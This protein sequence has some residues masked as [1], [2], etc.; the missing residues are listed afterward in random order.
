MLNHG[1]LVSCGSQQLKSSESLPANLNTRR[2]PGHFSILL[3]LKPTNRNFF[4][5][6]GTVAHDPCSVWCNLAAPLCSLQPFGPTSSAKFAACSL[7]VGQY[8]CVLIICLELILVFIGA[9]CNLQVDRL[10][11]YWRPHMRWPQSVV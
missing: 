4:R 6:P 1:V 5:S 3:V 11:S 2:G 10:G 9:H 8:N 7:R